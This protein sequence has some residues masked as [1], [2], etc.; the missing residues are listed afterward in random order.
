MKKII[1]FIICLGVLVGC[2]A[3]QVSSSQVEESSSSQV[4]ETS[5]SQIEETGVS[6]RNVFDFGAED[7]IDIINGVLEEQGDP[8]AFDIER[9]TQ[10]ESETDGVVTTHTSYDVDDNLSVVF[11]ET[12][13]GGL[14]HIFY[15]LKTETQDNNSLN[16]F[17]FL[18]GVSLAILEPLE[19]Y[20]LDAELGLEN[21]SEDSITVALGEYSEWSYIVDGNTIMLS[22]YPL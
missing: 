11:Y 8:I 1:C 9:M 15:F 21:F 16:Q 18:T 13:D 10:E 12:K 7:Y 4:E 20:I 2:G 17:G 5:S 14:T 22:I 19:K 3:E 6:E